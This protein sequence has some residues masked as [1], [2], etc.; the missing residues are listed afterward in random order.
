MKF[1][2][3]M[4]EII[5]FLTVS[6]PSVGC[7]AGAIVWSERSSRGVPKQGRASVVGGTPSDVARPRRRSRSRTRRVTDAM[8]RARTRTSSPS[9]VR[10]RGCERVRARVCPE[11]AAGG[12]QN[13]RQFWYRLLGIHAACV[14]RF[15][16]A[17][18]RRAMRAARSYPRCSWRSAHQIEAHAPS[19]RAIGTRGWRPKMRA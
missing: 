14:G 11:V 17:R 7:A 10:A 1:S 6:A 13:G 15:P 9:R 16:P 5:P 8:R 19:A 2:H 12:F 3:S 18:T 4:R